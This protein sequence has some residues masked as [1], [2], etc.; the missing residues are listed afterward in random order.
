MLTVYVALLAGVGCATKTAPEVAPTAPA[1]TE[2]SGAPEDPIVAGPRNVIESPP[3]PIHPDIPGQGPEVAWLVAVRKALSERYDTCMDG[4]VVEDGA[5][6][7]L[8][9]ATIGRDGAVM[10]VEVTRSSGRDAVDQCAVHAVRRAE[11][12][13]PPPEVGDPGS[14][15]RTPDLAF[16]P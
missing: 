12:P 4:I 9:A 6:T 7:A 2:A 13:P 11:L 5:D 3:P 16:V 14:P 10:A 15:V 8:V 1:P